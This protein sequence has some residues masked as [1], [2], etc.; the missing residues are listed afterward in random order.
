MTTPDWVN[1]V[2]SIT[3]NG[4]ELKN[5]TDTL[6]DSKLES[7]ILTLSRK[8]DDFRKISEQSP[9]S[10]KASVVKIESL[11]KDY[12]LCLAGI[13]LLEEEQLKR[14]ANI[15]EESL[16]PLY[17]MSYSY[18]ENF[19]RDSAIQKIHKNDSTS[20]NN[21]N[22]NIKLVRIKEGEFKECA[23]NSYSS[24]VLGFLR[25]IE[26]DYTAICRTRTFKDGEPHNIW[27]FIVL[28]TFF[29]T[30]A[31]RTS[32][33]ERTAVLNKMGFVL[34]L[35]EII[36]LFPEQI[37]NYELNLIHRTH[38]LSATEQVSHYHRYNQ[39][40]KFGFT[41][42]PHF[43]ELN[44]DESYSLWSIYNPDYLLWLKPKVRIDDFSLADYDFMIRDSNFFHLRAMNCYLEN[45][46]VQDLYF[47]PDDKLWVFVPELDKS[48]KPK[49]PKK[50][51]PHT[52][53]R[54]K[55]SNLG[56][57]SVNLDPTSYSECMLPPIN[58]GGNIIFQPW[59]DFKKSFSASY[60]AP[61]WSRTKNE[62]CKDSRVPKWC[63][64]YICIKPDPDDTTNSIIT[65]NFSET[66][67]GLQ[68]L[69]EYFG[70]IRTE[71]FEKYSPITDW[72][73]LDSSTIVKYARAYILCNVA[74]GI[75]TQ[76]AANSGIHRQH[77]IPELY[78]KKF[79]KDGRIDKISK[80]NGKKSWTNPKDV[81]F[82]EP[83]N[84]FGK[85]YPPE[86]EVILSRFEGD[87]GHLTKRKPKQNQPEVTA[88]KVVNNLWE[89]LVL[90]TFFLIFELRTKQ[91]YDS[92]HPGWD[93]QLSLLLSFAPD[94]IANLDVFQMDFRSEFIWNKENDEM[95]SWTSGLPFTQH[96]IYKDF[97]EIGTNE[98]I[99]SY[100]AINAPNMLLWLRHKKSNQS[101]TAT[102]EFV[103]SKI[104]G[105]L[106]SN[107]SRSLYFHPDDK[108][109]I[110]SAIEKHKP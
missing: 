102:P 11:V 81:D 23:E 77:W 37:A 53:L 35:P 5:K 3:E 99:V 15:E 70:E 100:W 79:A 10:P 40:M 47:H 33:Q 61:W 74:L 26:K 17:W 78:L 75:I 43:I 108:P 87:Y 16:E 58:K 39:P 71:L 30:S 91:Q 50:A 90:T 57:S 65:F 18:L 89:F 38:A 20:D 84:D 85:M 107:K 110:M 96:P 19:S 49:K 69:K 28:A 22:I 31:L 88:T 64:P 34:S 52:P 25:Q 62:S 72:S 21:V 55:K 94:T 63:Y 45:L 4:T 83:V 56:F 95:E 68:S 13:A 51:I 24:E 86:Y 59:R 103:M 106:G 29:V 41:E 66:A 7:L 14:K 12:I 1:N 92:K 54:T 46:E 44:S 9:Y 27:E 67:V 76:K 6:S 42:S 98:I 109:W 73:H 93:K 2:F 80:T 36:S 60:Y 97:E 104:Y 105:I 32:G 101:L 82:M 48:K 8:K